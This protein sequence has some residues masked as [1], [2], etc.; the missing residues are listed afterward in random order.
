MNKML[1]YYCLTKEKPKNKILRWCIIMLWDII[2]MSILGCF[3]F[4]DST[5][6]TLIVL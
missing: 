4:V 5:Y 3:L 6:F 2:G 1:G